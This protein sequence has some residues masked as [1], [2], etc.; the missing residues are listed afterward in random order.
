MYAELIEL[1]IYLSLMISRLYLEIEPGIPF[2][3][4]M[5]FIY[6][7]EVP[8]PCNLLICQITLNSSHG[9]QPH[10]LVML[11]QILGVLKGDGFGFIQ[12]YLS[13]SSN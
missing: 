12:T 13:T 4:P 3:W 2:H 8:Y 6:I 11:L 1:I 7:L 9:T 10:S 5:I